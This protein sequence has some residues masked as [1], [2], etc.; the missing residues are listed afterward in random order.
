MRCLAALLLVA[1]LPACATITSG[2]S[3]N[4]SVITDPP[5]STCQL[6]RDGMTVGIVNPTPGTVNVSKS[7]RDIAVTCTRAGN[8]GAVQLV[9]AELQAAT[10]GNILLGGVIGLAVDAASGAMSRY[11]EA[12][13]VILPPAQFTSVAERDAFF[14]S[15][16]AEIRRRYAEQLREVQ[17][18]CATPGSDACSARNATIDAQRDAELAIIEAQRLSVRL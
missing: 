17:N 3:Q 14:A 10:A 8:L 7:T 15:R 2:T 6:Q 1:L 13:T 11:P 5:G 4:I 16:A 12:V 18:A 9:R